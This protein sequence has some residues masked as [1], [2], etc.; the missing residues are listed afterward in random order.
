[1]CMCVH[2]FIYLLIDA[3]F[4]HLPFVHVQ[5]HLPFCFNILIIIF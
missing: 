3:P 4:S 2:D 5:V 1:M